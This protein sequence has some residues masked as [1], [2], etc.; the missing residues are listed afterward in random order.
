MNNTRFHL[1]LLFFM[2]QMA[3]SNAA[4]VDPNIAYCE[5][6]SFLANKGITL[7]RKTPDLKASRR[8]GT[9]QG[10]N[11]YYVFNADNGKGF[12]IIS[13]DDRTPAVLGYGV[14]G[15]LDTSNLP[16][17][18]KSWLQSYQDEI[19]YLDSIKVTTSTAKANMRRTAKVSETRKPIPALLTTKWNQ[20]EPYWNSCPI[21][22]DLRGYTGCVATAMAQVMYHHRDRSVKA[23]TKEIPSYQYRFNSTYYYRENSVPA[24][25]PI[26]WDNMLPDYHNVQAT[27]VQK[28]AV[29][30]FMHLCG[31]AVQMMYSPFASGAY[32]Q[33]VAK[34][35]VNYFGYDES[36]SF[37]QRAD[38]TMENWNRMIYNELKNNRPVVYGGMSASST[39]GGH[40]FVIDG[41]DGDEYFHVNWGWGG[42]G[43]GY[44]LLTSLLPDETGIGAGE[45]AGGYQYYQ[46]AI[47]NAQ[48]S[49]GGDY[50]DIPLYVSDIKLLNDG[51]IATGFGNAGLYENK[52]TVGFGSLNENGN[53][54]PLATTDCT[55]GTSY[56]TE[57]LYRDTFDI[58]SQLST[59]GSYKIVPI[60]HNSNN[61]K[62]NICWDNYD[63]HYIKAV[64]ADDGTISMTTMQP[65]YDLECEKLRVGGTLSAIQGH[66]LTA[67][68]Q[69]KG[70]SFDGHIHF[71][72]YSSGHRL[73]Q[74]SVYVGIQQGGTET[75]SVGFLPV[76]TGSYTA[77]VCTDIEGKNILRKADFKIIDEERFDNSNA[78]LVSNINLR[79][80]SENN[81]GRD[82]GAMLFTIYGDSIS[83]GIT[84]YARK[85]MDRATPLLVLNKKTGTSWTPVDSTGQAMENIR[86]D[87]TYFRD[88]NFTHLEPGIYKL[89]IKYQ[90]WSDST[91]SYITDWVGDFDHYQLGSGVTEYRAR[92]HKE[93]LFAGT[94]T[95][96][97]DVL[98][99]DLRG[100]KAANIKPNNNPN[101]IYIVREGDNVSSLKGK[102]IVTFNQDETYTANAI[103]LND[104]Y[105]FY[106]PVSF[107]AKYASYI[108]MFNDNGT[109]STLQLPFTPTRATK[110][111]TVLPIG[112][113]S[114][115]A[116]D[117][118][119]FSGNN[120]RNAIFDSIK[121]NGLEGNLPY[122]IKLD[123]VRGQSVTFTANDASFTA[124]PKRT[125]V[126]SE[127]YKFI[128]TMAT[129]TLYNVFTLSTDGMQFDFHPSFVAKPFR[130][131]FFGYGE[132]VDGENTTFYP[133]V[134]SGKMTTSGITNQNIS[135][136]NESIYDIQ[137]VKLSKKHR[138]INIIK[139]KKVF[140]Q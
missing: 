58:K 26:D 69:N 76:D 67:T 57:V 84:L 127:N 66:S 64:V 128:G 42:M 139:S 72:I 132:V 13:G 59:P 28:K 53:V 7:S 48:P 30:D 135:M 104:N 82:E 43:D 92:G 71:F 54:T 89:T 140:I 33:E 108:R 6:K 23:T 100:C 73:Y 34:A 137:G 40:C 106:T 11:D 97:N 12:V 17:S 24:G 18:I 122:I 94:Y 44:F 96:P 93:Q 109:W 77:T 46:D 138:G 74:D 120:D 15:T 105:D 52:F 63:R 98:A 50:A 121:E 5:A 119:E 4:P 85:T 14:N 3:I 27:E 134:I 101:T 111:N 19:H 70:I 36:T 124:S 79:G 88:F 51:K 62:W 87:Q 130:A 117:I 129:D 60:S 20:D 123:N 125:G 99:A 56:V 112:G 102:N 78:F 37:V 29:A 31:D 81:P 47:I 107:T 114:T 131:C 118:S 115:D 61:T 113:S 95:I 10:A 21:F 83:G 75:M 86:E 32:D 9:A 45:V 25:T 55:I 35:M 68:I 2:G 8:I 110:G 80:L 39:G 103:N 41:Y 38:Y 136:Q 65:V 1:F 22:G 16:Y 133:L 49:V 90:H 91:F 116:L 126:R